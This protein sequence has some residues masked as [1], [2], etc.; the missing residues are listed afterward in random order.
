MD[1]RC[2]AI[3]RNCRKILQL[4][5]PCVTPCL[6]WVPYQRHQDQRSTNVENK[7]QLGVLTATIMTQLREVSK[8]TYNCHCLFSVLLTRVCSMTHENGKNKQTRN[9]HA[10]MSVLFSESM[11]TLRVNSSKANKFKNTLYLV[12]QVHLHRLNIPYPKCLGPEVFQI[13]GLFV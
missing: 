3:D 2:E 9:Q 7:K 10:Y 12:I 4:I 13:S 8:I 1:L 11:I 6:F 5:F